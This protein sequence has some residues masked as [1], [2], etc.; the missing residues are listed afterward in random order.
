MKALKVSYLVIVILSIL[1]V[2]CEKENICISGQGAI[3]TQ[4]LS[5]ADF[6]GIDLAGASNVTIHQ[7]TTQEVKAT[8]HLNIINRLKTNVSENV[9]KIQLEDGCYENYELSFEI[10]VPNIEDLKL[11]GSGNIVMND[12][13]NQGNLDVE[14][15][16]SGNIKI[17]K[18][19]GAEVL[20]VE[21]SGSGQVLGNDD[22]ENLKTLTLAIS[23]SGN[24]SGFSIQTDDCIVDI[25]GSGNCNVFARNNLD[26]TISGSGSVFYK[27]N[28]QI[29]SNI[30]GSG[31]IIDAN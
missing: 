10:T 30:T 9:W 4:T 22:F 25:S 21:I 31:S 29:T 7:G 11:S 5:I 17:N 20:A 27:G 13:E 16:G 23:G 3:T 6:S 15:S 18:F 12:F 19:G 1:V 26:V 2:S 28:P 24:Y 14:I 8:G